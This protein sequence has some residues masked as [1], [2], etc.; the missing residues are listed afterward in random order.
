MDLMIGVHH[1]QCDVIIPSQINPDQTNSTCWRNG[2]PHGP[3]SNLPKVL[4]CDK[5]YLHCDGLEKSWT[6]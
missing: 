4:S 2:L 1:R 3:R 6:F 5:L